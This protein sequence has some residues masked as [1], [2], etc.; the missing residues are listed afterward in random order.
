MKFF[1]DNCVPVGLVKA[2]HE[3]V[4]NEGHEVLHLRDRF[5]AD[6]PDDKWIPEIGQEGGW[7]LVSHDVGIMRSRFESEVWRRA[8]LP[9]FF[10]AK[11]LANERPIK[12]MEAVA[13]H[14]DEIVEVAEK[15]KRGASY[16]IH[17][18]GKP[19]PRN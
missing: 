5:P 19:K 2:L 15:M 8:G 13:R 14:W 6:T 16:V 18:R 11:G 10:F 17:L 4:R 7:V 12:Q 9:T 3:L 1:F